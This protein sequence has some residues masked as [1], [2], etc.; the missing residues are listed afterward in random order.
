MRFTP[1]LD[2]LG[3][4]IKDDA[5]PDWL[6]NVIDSALA[7]LYGMTDWG[8]FEGKKR[9]PCPEQPILLTGA[10]LG[11]YHCPH[12][13]EMQIASMPHLAPEAD[14]ELMMGQP[15]PPGYEEKPKARPDFDPRTDYPERFREGPI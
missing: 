3:I 12:C 13:G 7:A 8:E 5:D 11:Q 6:V 10:P 15:W 4:K 1:F 9:K 2:H 14:Y